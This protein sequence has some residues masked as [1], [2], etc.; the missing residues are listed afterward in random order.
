MGALEAQINADAEK[1]APRDPI[2][3]TALRDVEELRDN[4]TQ[5]TEHFSSLLLRHDLYQK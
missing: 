5:G 1:G 3:E 2:R 4:L